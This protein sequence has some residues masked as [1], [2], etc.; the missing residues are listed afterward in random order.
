MKKIPEAF[1]DF[2]SRLELT[3]RE[4]DEASRQH[5]HMRQ[6]IQK[7]MEVEDNFLSG[8]YGRRTA[9]RPLNDIDIF[10]VRKSA[11][12]PGAR[13]VTPSQMIEEMKA[14]LESIYPSKKATVS[15]RAL[16]MEFEGSGIAYDVVPAFAAERDVYLIPDMEKDEWVRTNPKIHQEKSTA[17]NQR[18][19]GKLIPLLKAVKHA[20]N[21]YGRVGRSFHL[22]VLSWQVVTSDPGAFLD[23]LVLLLDGLV[24]RMD[25]PCPDPAGLGPAIQPSPAKCQEAKK[26]LA[27]MAR[28][29]TDAKR[30]ASEGRLAEAHTTLQEIFGDAWQSR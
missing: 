21:R 17:A 15:A 8:S 6:Q 9:I 10:V 12:G 4:R 23:G 30:L 18:A 22:E 20:N 19:G 27:K 14:T 11:T 13:K 28:L 26:L 16:N 25:L 2:L 7:K 1:Q 3:Q 29:A 5:I 24:P